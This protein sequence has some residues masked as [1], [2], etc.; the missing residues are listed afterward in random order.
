MI[1]NKAK[2]LWIAI[3][4]SFISATNAFATPINVT[5]NKPVTLNGTYGALR[6]AS[7]WSSL[8][9]AP[10]GS[11]NDGVFA[12]EGTL[13]NDGSIWWD[14]T[15]QGSG[16][17]SLVIDLE[18]D[19]FIT[20]I[21]TQADNNDNYLIEFYEPTLATWLSLGYWGPIGGSGLITRPAGDHVTPYGT[22][23]YASAIRLSAFGGDGYYSY[24]EF[25]AI[26]N[27]VPEPG[28]V[29]LLGLAL[30]GLGLSRRKSR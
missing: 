14:A 18:G 26:G 15:V 22:G 6:P 20:G 11:I 3:G 21:L 5:L 30:A 27:Q 13:W 12:S 8:P 29:A 10:A 7:V 19:F 2:S 16:S 9:V 25:V 1:S 23:F 4:L 24:S 17:N 28:T